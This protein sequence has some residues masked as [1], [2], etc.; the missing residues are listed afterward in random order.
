MGVM[1]RITGRK[2]SGIHIKPENRGKFTARAAG[3]GNSMGKQIGEDLKSGSK[4]S[5]AAKKE[6]NFARMAKRHWKPL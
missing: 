1:N 5:P 2:G 6:A 4:A 3:H